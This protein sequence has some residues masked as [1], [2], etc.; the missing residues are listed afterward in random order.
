[1]PPAESIPLLIVEDD[2]NIRYLLEVA[3]SRL[4]IYGPIK[5]APDGEAALEALHACATEELP[6]LIVTD[7]SM[8]RVNGIDLLHGLKRDARLSAI[9]V[10]V[11][12]SSDIPND[13]AMALAAGA[14]AFVA[15]PHGLEALM[16]A[17]LQLRSCVES[18]SPVT[19]R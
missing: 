18:A 1:V 9:P 2:A 19:G 10:A 8:P 4:G 11:I 3:A 7:L 12:T 6:S 5:V 14:C 17:L 13:R 16:R 15:K